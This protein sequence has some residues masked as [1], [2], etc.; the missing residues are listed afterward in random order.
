MWKK[1]GC[2]RG[3]VRVAT[4]GSGRSASLHSFFREKLGLTLGPADRVGHRWRRDIGGT[5]PGHA[6]GRRVR[7]DPPSGPSSPR[8][9]STTA[10]RLGPA[11]SGAASPCHTRGPWSTGDGCARARGR[12]PGS[13]WPWSPSGTLARCTGVSRC[14]LGHD[15]HGEAGCGRGHAHVGQSMHDAEP[16]F[17]SGPN[18]MIVGSSVQARKLYRYD[19]RA[20]WP[21]AVAMA[22]SRSCRSAHAA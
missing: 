11:D 10:A 18:A 17:A 1:R 12:V 4:N 21:A 13:V 14:S 22:R 2:T 9:A 3:D 5:R 19:G 16:P 6:T 15:L 7:R 20:L 8:S